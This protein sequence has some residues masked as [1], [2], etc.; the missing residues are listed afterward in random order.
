MLTLTQELDLADGRSGRKQ[1]AQSLPPSRKV[2]IVAQSFN[3][4][5]LR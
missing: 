3:S 2:A 4:A 5:E 1:G